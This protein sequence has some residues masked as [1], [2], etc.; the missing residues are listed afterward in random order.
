MN[1]FEQTLRNELRTSEQR[2]S[3][4]I[5]ARLAGSRQVAVAKARRHPWARIFLPL[6]GM[7]AASVVALVVVWAPLTDTPTP[8]MQHPVTVDNTEFFEDLEFYYWLAQN[9]GKQES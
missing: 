4:E 5:E 3:P 7:L 6:S 9:E 8:S 2:L 1:D